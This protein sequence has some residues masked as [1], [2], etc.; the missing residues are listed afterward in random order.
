MPVGVNGGR[1]FE[2]LIDSPEVEVNSIVC[3]DWCFQFRKFTR[4]CFEIIKNHLNVAVS[5]EMYQDA[6]THAQFCRL[7][8]DVFSASYSYLRNKSYR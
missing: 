5:Q 8:G 2:L 3:S 1:N 4:L 7:L 6:K